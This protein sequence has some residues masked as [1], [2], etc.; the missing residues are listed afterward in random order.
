[1]KKVLS[2]ASI[3]LM[4]LMAG[5]SK[6]STV[7]SFDVKDGYRCIILTEDLLEP[8][9]PYFYAVEKSG[10]ETVPASYINSFASDLKFGIIEASDHSIFGIVGLDKPNVV[11]AIHDKTNDSTWPHRSDHEGFEEAGKK[12]LIRKL[13]EK[14]RNTNLVL[15]SD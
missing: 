11:L 8:N 12:E 6:Y 14:T 3:M 4:G 10:N 5:C 1:M 9:D 2:V 7:Q 13:S 15:S